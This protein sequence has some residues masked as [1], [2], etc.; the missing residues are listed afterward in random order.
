MYLLFLSSKFNPPVSPTP[1]GQTSCCLFPSPSPACHTD[2][3]LQPSFPLIQLSQLPTPAGIPWEPTSQ[4]C[5]GASSP[6]KQVGKLLIITLTPFLQIQSPSLTHS[7]I[8][9]YLLWPRLT[10]CPIPMGIGRS[11]WN[12][13]NSSLIW[14]LLVPPLW[15]SSP[16]P[17]LNSS[18]QYLETHCIQ[19]PQGPHLAEFQKHSPLYSTQL[20]DPKN[21]KRQQKPRTKHPLNK[22]SD[23]TT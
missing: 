1:P 18:S 14:T 23:I 9:D 19:S 7:S 4:A 21:Q 6:D 13:T 11:W 2:F 3:R 12:T 5:R 10:F 22:K 20:P 15:M 17:F 16:P 8:E